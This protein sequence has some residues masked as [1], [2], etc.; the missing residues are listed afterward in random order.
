MPT[1][2]RMKPGN[3]EKVLIVGG[4]GRLGGLLRLAW[5]RQG[6]EGLVWQSRR[7]GDGLGL[8]PLGDPSGFARAAAGATT[9]F[10]LA[11]VTAG[12]PSELALNSDLAL[13]SIRAARAAS[14][15]QVFLA[16]SAAVYGR[17][18]TGTGEDGVPQPVSDYGRAKLAMEE[19]ALRNTGNW[20]N[21]PAVT[22]LRIGNVA[23]ADQLLGTRAANGPQ[24][25]DICADGHGPRRSYI[26][27]QA[28]SKM[29]HKL[30]ALGRGGA[31]LPPILNIALEGAV[32]MDD[33]LEADGRSWRPMPAP[34]TVI[35]ELCLDITRL[36]QVIGRPNRA[37]AIEI[38]ADYRGLVPHP[39]AVT[40]R[41]GGVSR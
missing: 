36:S 30:F 3:T 33:L 34:P 32:A 38:V 35:P 6:R 13:A 37:D 31:T 9:I 1:A 21:G 23:G 29:L 11:G 22:C 12:G 16:S 25:L 18:E 4:T 10:C 40:E 17:A 39:T 28:L 7:A 24:M 26:G 15:P 14:V 41:R 27:P 2:T 19:V 8:D 5:A 20:D